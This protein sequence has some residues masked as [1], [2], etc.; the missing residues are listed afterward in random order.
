MCENSSILTRTIFR[1]L[2]K[3]T[4]IFEGKNAVHQMCQN[5][6]IME[7]DSHT[8]TFGETFLSALKFGSCT[9]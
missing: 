3:E 6:K 8:H 4:K 1:N 5:K 2:N 7:N 9:V